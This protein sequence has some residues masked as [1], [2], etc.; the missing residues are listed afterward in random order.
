[1][2]LSGKKKKLLLK[3]AKRLMT[4]KKQMDGECVDE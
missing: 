2:K 1:V 4:E 3:E